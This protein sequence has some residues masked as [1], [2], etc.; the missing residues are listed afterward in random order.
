MLAAV[1]GCVELLL[2]LA[3][4]CMFLCRLTVV[5]LYEGWLLYFAVCGGEIELGCIAA[6]YVAEYG[7][8]IEH[9]S[10]AVWTGS[11]TWMCG[12]VFVSHF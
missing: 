9:V 7:R 6:W 4:C 5:R 10:K 12:R 11:W 2:C 8:V 1:F 3:A